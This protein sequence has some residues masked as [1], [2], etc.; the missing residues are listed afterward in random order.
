MSALS[1]LNVQINHLVRMQTDSVGLRRGLR[2][3]ISSKCLE[4]ANAADLVMQ[5]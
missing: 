1:N 4:A 3:Y 2:S 5:L